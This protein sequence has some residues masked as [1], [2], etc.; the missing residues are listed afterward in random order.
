LVGVRSARSHSEEQIDLI[1]VEAMRE[2]DVDIS[3][4]FPKPRT[5][6]R[7]PADAGAAVPASAEA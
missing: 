4:E 1:V 2:L 5:E 6:D 3:R 7:A